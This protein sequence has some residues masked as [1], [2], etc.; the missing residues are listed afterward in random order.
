MSLVGGTND[1]IGRD[2]L[3]GQTTLMVKEGNKIH[4]LMKPGDGAFGQEGFE[5]WEEE[6]VFEEEE[7]VEESFE[8]QGPRGPAPLGSP[9]GERISAKPP[10]R[11]VVSDGK[12]LRNKNGMFWLGQAS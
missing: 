8:D 10:D 11:L 1:W 4:L 9:P 5:E 7:V 3:P 12:N 6:E 2:D